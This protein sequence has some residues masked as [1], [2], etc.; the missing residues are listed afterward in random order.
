MPIPELRGEKVVHYT[1][2]ILETLC[3]DP[4]F[5]YCPG[6]K[7]QIMTDPKLGLIKRTRAINPRAGLH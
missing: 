1:V 4:I 7:F 6:Y 3:V 5:L 2:E